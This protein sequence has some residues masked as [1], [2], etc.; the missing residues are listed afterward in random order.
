MDHYGRAID[1]YGRAIDAY[2]AFLERYPAPKAA[3][4][5][6]GKQSSTPP[7][8]APR[9][10]PQIPLR[11]GLTCTFATVQHESIHLRG[12]I[13]LE[14]AGCGSLVSQTSWFGCVIDES[15]KGNQP[16]C[17]ARI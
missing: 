14:W 8:G 10:L 4:R 2:V 13:N 16:P 12:L 11:L 17:V 6:P 5:Q 1:H 15:L 7:C 3:V 9:R